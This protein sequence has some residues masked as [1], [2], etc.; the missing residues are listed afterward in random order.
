MIQH[1]CLPHLCVD[2]F[3][4]LGPLL[5]FCPLGFGPPFGLLPVDFVLLLPV[6]LLSPCARWTVGLPVVALCTN[7]IASERACAWVVAEAQPSECTFK[8]SLSEFGAGLRT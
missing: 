2:V 1:Y 6:G 4:A 8:Y 3:S 7:G 5:S